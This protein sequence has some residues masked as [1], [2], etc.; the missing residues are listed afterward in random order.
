[1][2]SASEHLNIWLVGSPCSPR[3]SQGFSP[4]PQ[5][6]SI[7]SSALN[8]L[9]QCIVTQLILCLI[10]AVSPKWNQPLIFTGSTDAE[11]EAPV[12]WP[13]GAKSQLTGKDPDAGKNWGQEEK[14]VTEDE[15]V[16]WHHQL[17]GHLRKLEDSERQGSLACCSPC[18]H[19][20]SD[21]TEWL[22]NNNELSERK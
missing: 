6:K 16:G 4:V 14:R 2:H 20:D 15:T 12:L 1:M 10:K 3:D 13:L 17:D 19:K 7:N 8:L 11:A 21:T 18:G 5:Y 9:C 22:N